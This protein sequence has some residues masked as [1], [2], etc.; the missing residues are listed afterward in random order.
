MVKLL[1]FFNLA[2]IK[3]MTFTDILIYLK[4]SLYV[5]TG[6]NNDDDE[7]GGSEI[8]NCTCDDKSQVISVDKCLNYQIT[9]HLLNIQFCIT[10]SNKY[11]SFIGRVRPP[12]LLNF[13]IISPFNNGSYCY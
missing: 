12:F 4:L 2:E 7:D 1:S 3:V 6:L 13:N 5:V 11:I 8:N 9:L 10:S